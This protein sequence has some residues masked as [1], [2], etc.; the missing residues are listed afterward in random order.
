ME[1]IEHSTLVMRNNFDEQP[2]TGVQDASVV[3]TARDLLDIG[4]GKT[5]I[6]PAYR[7]Q[8][9]YVR[10]ISADDFKRLLYDQPFVCPS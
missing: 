8:H 10:D 1:S 2:Y 3:I 4:N 9:Q 5:L 6:S 7:W